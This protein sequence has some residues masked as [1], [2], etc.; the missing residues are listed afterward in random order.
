MKVH[1]I[2][3]DVRIQFCEYLHEWRVEVENENSDWETLITFFEKSEAINWARNK[4]NIK[5]EW[6]AI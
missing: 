6:F 5:M 1:Y 3:P 2:F 4:N